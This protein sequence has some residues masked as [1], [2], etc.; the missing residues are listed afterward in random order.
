MK[1]LV[2]GYQRV[3]ITTPPEEVIRV[4]RRLTEFA[5]RQGYVLADVF[6]DAD[7]SRPFAALSALIRAARRH[8][9]AAVLVADPDHFAHNPTAQAVMRDRVQRETGARVIFAPETA[10]LGLAIR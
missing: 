3:R 4:R 6:V 5:A 10:S 7:E 1:P 9:A 8:D 2:Y